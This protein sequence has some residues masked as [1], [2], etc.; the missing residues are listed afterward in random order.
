MNLKFAPKLTKK[1]KNIH[2]Q[3]KILYSSIQRKL[4]LFVSN[5]RHPSLR[6][7]KL[8]G[9]GEEVWSI[10]ITRSIRMVYVVLSEGEAYFF[11]IGKHEEVYE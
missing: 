2:S 8:S 6:L 7:H 4:K 9:G 11:K 1:L 5:P 10:S 3:D